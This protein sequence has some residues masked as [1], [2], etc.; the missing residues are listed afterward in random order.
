MRYRNVCLYEKLFTTTTFPINSTI[1]CAAIPLRY[2]CPSAHAIY[3]IF[4]YVCTCIN[5][6]WLE[7]VT[8]WCRPNAL[9]QPQSPLTPNAR[10]PPHSRPHWNANSLLFALHAL[11]A[12]IFWVQGSLCVSPP[13]YL[14]FVCLYVSA[15]GALVPTIAV[16]ALPPPSSTP[17]NA[18]RTLSA[19]T[20]RT[21]H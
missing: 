14:L 3:N 9:I 18:W 10:F 13:I 17:V 16:D 1:T 19:I 11:N 20:S 6:V 4:T 2:A 7:C 5:I 8:Y 21:L 15:Y 12:F